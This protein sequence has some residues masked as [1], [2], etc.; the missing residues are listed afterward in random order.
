MNDFRDR[1]ANM[2]AKR[3]ALLALDLN[4]RIEATREPIAVVGLGCRF[5]GGAN[6][7]EKFWAL[8]DSGTDAIREVPADRWDIDAFYDADVDAPG[9]MSTRSGGFL[10]DIS[11]FDPAFFGIAP[12]EAITM[13]PQQ[14]LLLEVTWEALEHA[15]I[16]LNDSS[17]RRPACSSAFAITTIRCG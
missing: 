10:D 4:E 12:R 14:R 2:S 9:K 3:L 1:I 7:P 6:D 17:G 11:H 8:L 13:D 16:S 5:P 15:G